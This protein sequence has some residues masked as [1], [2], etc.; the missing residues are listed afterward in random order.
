MRSEFKTKN[1]WTIGINNEI[2]RSYHL[3]PTEHTSPLC[4]AISPESR[5]VSR[6]NLMCS[7]LW[8]LHEAGYLSLP[9]CATWT[10]S[11]PLARVPH[12]PSSHHLISSSH[13]SAMDLG[14]ISRE[15][16]SVSSVIFHEIWILVRRMCDKWYDKIWE[17]IHSSVLRYWA[18]SLSTLPQSTSTHLCP[19][20]HVLSM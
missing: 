1:I 18:Q 6:L 2:L 4:H 7:V 10:Y 14:D 20:C 17:Q 5:I 9:G 8:P 11:T 12:S 3:S 13:L 19:S 16:W 15:I